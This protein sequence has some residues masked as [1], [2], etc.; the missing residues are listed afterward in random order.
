MLQ[1]LD[2]EKNNPCSASLLLKPTADTLKYMENSW[3]MGEFN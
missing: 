3:S 2:P 1:I